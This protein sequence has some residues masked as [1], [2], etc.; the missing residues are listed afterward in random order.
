MQSEALIPDA[1]N[2]AR[3]VVVIHA[4]FPTRYRLAIQEYFR[5]GPA[6]SGTPPLSLSTLPPSAY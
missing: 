3:L 6:L 1:A 5:N 4:R 2:I